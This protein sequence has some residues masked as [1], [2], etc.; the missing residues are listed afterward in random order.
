MIEPHRY[1]PHKEALVRSVIGPLQDV[2]EIGSGAN[3]YGRRAKH[4]NYVGV[5]VDRRVRPDVVASATHL[6]F[7]D[8]V[9]DWVVALDTVE[10]VG[11]I[12]RCLSEVGRVLR[13]RGSMLITTPNFLGL[14]IYDSLAD[15]T[16]VHRFSWW[17]LE[18]V[19]RMNGFE[20]AAKLRLMLHVFLPKSD[21]SPSFL[22]YLQQSICIVSRRVF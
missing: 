3:G 20:T 11:D 8:G 15:P 19:L 7:R 13:S 6:P 9:F 12:H 5:D 1:W 21:R 16:H 14:G 2:L 22:K 17:S 4:R 18:R 10:H